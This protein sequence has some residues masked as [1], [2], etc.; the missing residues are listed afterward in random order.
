MKKIKIINSVKNLSKIKNIRS[1]K[2]KLIIYFSTLILL[3]SFAIGLISIVRTTDGMTVESQKMLSKLVEEDSKL[4]DSRLE[5]QKRTL[6]M[7]ATITEIRS[8]NWNAQLPFLKGQIQRTEFLKFGVLNLSGNV[9]FSDGN[10]IKLDADNALLK[11][12]EGEEII[13]VIKSPIDDELILIS[14]T[15]IERSGRVVG[16][17]IGFLDIH[18]LSNITDDTGY[19]ELGYAYMINSKGNTVAHPDIDKVLTQ[20]NPIEE[21]ENDKS[22]KPLVSLFEKMLE[23]KSGIS[24]YTYQGLDLY[25]GYAPVEGTDWIL[26]ITANQKEALAAI[27]QLRKAILIAVIIILLLSVGVTYYVGNV[28]SKPIVNAVE[29]SKRIAGFDLT[30]NIATV[31]LQR[32]DEVGEL[33]NAFQSIIDNF[34]RVINEVNITS[35]QVAAA[36]QELTAT[37]Q[38]SS[39]ASEEV[40]KTV[41]EIAQGASDQALSTEEGSSKAILLGES[42]EKNKDY[43]NDLNK[44][45][46][47]ISLIVNEGLIEIDNL[48]KITDESVVA[49]KEI[50]NVILK[51]NESSN[52]IGQASKVIESIAEQTNLLALNAAI[53]AARAGEAGRGFAVVADEIRKLAEKSSTSTKAIDKIVGELLENSQNAVVTMNRVSAIADEQTNSV[54]NNKEK[55]MLITEA[56]NHAINSIKNLY[57]SGKEM[58]HMKDEILNKLQDLTAIAEENAASTEEASASMEEQAA[59]MEQIVAASEGLATLS[60]NLHKAINIFKL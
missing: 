35:E 32:E 52:Q 17:L 36:S 14:I 44:E 45:G 6:E 47:K 18:T 23:E 37:S 9:N 2:T 15:P 27:P 50:Q 41:E 54:F 7:I 24:S 40:T 28:I 51:T 60:Q 53:E 4:I 19:G 58:E 3:S 5:T 30:N 42:I 31:D 26:V 49:T 21:L 38:Q 16:A 43:I 59:S 33:S 48:T 8:M 39:L 46:E 12:L 29:Y 56:M 57:V 25:A 55:Y 11:A 1:I 10:T 22:I 13:D 34:R 20:Y